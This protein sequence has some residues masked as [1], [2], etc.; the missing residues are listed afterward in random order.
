MEQNDTSSLVR[1]AALGLLAGILLSP[2]LWGF[3][4]RG[5]F[6]LLPLMG[7]AHVAGAVLWQ[8][9]LVVVP[10]LAA[11]LFPKKKIFPL[12]TIGALALLCC[13]DLSRL[14][15]W[16]WC[17][18]LILSLG[19]LKG[20]ATAFR[21]LLA[22][23]YTWSGLN[24]LSPYF[25]EGNFSWFCEAFALT[26]N[27]AHWPALGY[28]VAILETALGL[29]LIWP[30]TSKIAAWGL[31][32]MH[33]LIL[34]FLVK[35]QWNYVVIPWNI[36]LAVMLWLLVVS[37]RFDNKA[38]IIKSLVNWPAA[39]L[40][41]VWVFPA[42]YWLGMWPYTLSWQLYSNN[43]AEATFESDRSNFAQNAAMLHQWDQYAFDN[44]ARL[45][46]DDWSYGALGVPMVPGKH[47][48]RQ[49]VQYLCE[50]SGSNGR[51]VV[52]T[53]NQWNK[54]AEQWETLNC[55]DEAR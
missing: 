46:L 38:L 4:S 19:V 11:L 20:D 8:G 32:A 23:I 6:P 7:A 15:P 52:L 37:G 55:G 44:G 34:V 31:V 33:A 41:L 22:G 9:L 2:A 5:A 14:Q 40:L 29:G 13:L 42:L 16:V 36:A 10:V 45:Q 51:L 50:Q 39:V 17:Y 54:K 53:V 47:T 1:I 18:F 21:L 3:A 48:F 27:A 30:K 49:T 12:L 25:A 28:G 43:Q 35:L 24:K 26:K